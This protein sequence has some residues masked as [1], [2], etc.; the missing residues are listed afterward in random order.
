MMKF[1]NLHRPRNKIDKDNDSLEQ[2]PMKRKCQRLHYSPSPYDNNELSYEDT[3][4][5]LQDEWSK[6][7]A[8]RRVLKELLIAT[9]NEHQTWV[10]AT[11]AKVKN[12]LG[13]VSNADEE[14]LGEFS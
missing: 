4:S 7:K 6:Q 13:K 10:K 14:G 2:L 12:C 5:T 9:M 1:K 11:G 8:K 3:Y